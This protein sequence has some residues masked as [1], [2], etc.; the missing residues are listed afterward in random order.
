M[1]VQLF[2]KYGADLDA[3]DLRGQT[4]LHTAVIRLSQEPKRY[5]EYKKIIKELLF[6]GA[7]RS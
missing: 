3:Q 4:P 1:N 6:H 2:I 7:N 5:V